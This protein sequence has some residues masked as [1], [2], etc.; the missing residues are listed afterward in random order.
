MYL[1]YKG[2]TGKLLHYEMLNDE[3]VEIILLNKDNIQLKFICKEYQISIPN[4]MGNSR[5]LYDIEK[6]R[7][8][9]GEDD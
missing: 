5:I 4:V 2:F 3:N 1:K 6:Q 9:G 7:K 8:E